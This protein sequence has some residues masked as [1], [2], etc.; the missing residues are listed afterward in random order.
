MTRPDAA[1]TDLANQR[2]KKI[3]DTLS[4]MF[5]ELSSDWTWNWEWEWESFRDNILFRDRML[6]WLQHPVTDSDP[7]SHGEDNGFVNNLSPRIIG[8]SSIRGGGFRENTEKNR[9]KREIR[10]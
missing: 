1:P 2:L 4:I 10:Q 8:T 3:G 7:R 5:V 9:F 6:G